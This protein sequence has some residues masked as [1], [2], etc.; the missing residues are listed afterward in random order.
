[1]CAQNDWLVK[2][3][4]LKIEN[5]GAK[6]KDKKNKTHTRGGLIDDGSMNEPAI[7]RSFAIFIYIALVISRPN[8]RIK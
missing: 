6:I 5:L 2:W 1:M 4:I 3:S 7:C 8:E